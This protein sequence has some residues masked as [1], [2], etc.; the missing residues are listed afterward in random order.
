MGKVRLLVN[1]MDELTSLRISERVF[2]E[3]SVMFFT[4]TC[5]EDN[6]S[7]SIMSL[8]GFYLVRAEKWQR[9]RKEEGRGSRCLC[10]QQVVQTWTHF[11]ERT[12]VARIWNC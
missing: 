12:C 5:L 11:S 6:I 2:H 9:E 1:K 4:E 8:A 10:E 3:S 7:D